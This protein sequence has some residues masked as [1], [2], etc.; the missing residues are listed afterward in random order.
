MFTIITEKISAKSVFFIIILAKRVYYII[1][2]Y[3]MFKNNFLVLS[4]SVSEVVENQNILA[5]K[6]YN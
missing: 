3:V 6:K 5:R 2:L 1:A 4:D